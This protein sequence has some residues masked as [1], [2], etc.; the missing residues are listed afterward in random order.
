MRTVTSQR[1]T[2]ALPAEGR[3]GPSDDDDDDDYYND[4]VGGDNDYDAEEDDDDNEDDNDKDAKSSHDD[5]HGAGQYDHDHGVACYDIVMTAHDIDY[6]H[7][8]VCHGDDDNTCEDDRTRA[9]SFLAETALFEFST[10]FWAEWSVYNIY[11]AE[12]WSEHQ[13]CNHLSFPTT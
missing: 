13:H 8:F 9:F 3:P 6:N 12:C 2:Q 5:N 4:D 1:S 7:N 10:Q 11:S